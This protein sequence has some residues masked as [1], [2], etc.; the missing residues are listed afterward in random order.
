MD[1]P[2]VAAKHSFRQQGIYVRSIYRN[3]TLFGLERWVM[4]SL[5][6]IRFVLPSMI[7]NTLAGRFAFPRNKVVV[8]VYCLLKVLTLLLILRTGSGSTTWAFIIAFLLL[9]DL[10]VYLLSVIFLG[11]SGLYA[12][13]A[14]INRSI[15]LALL[16]FL[17]ITAAVSIVYLHIAAL[18]YAGNSVTSWHQA[19]YFSI[20]TGTT[21]GFGDIAPCTP[22]GRLV[23]SLHA[24]GAMIFF[25]VVFTM[26]VSHIR[27]E[28]PKQGPV[29]KGQDSASNPAS[30]AT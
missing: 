11:R 6:V 19:F 4:L 20:I 2:D 9:V 25:G 26:L 23:A 22:Q 8:D 3:K 21:I 7:I 1:N 29:N 13:P 30:P 10:Y 24:L 17:E 18:C 27:L 14:S 12:Q 15:L 5:A 16:N 28:G